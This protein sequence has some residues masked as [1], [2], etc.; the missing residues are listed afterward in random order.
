MTIGGI[1]TDVVGGADGEVGHRASEWGVAATKA[2]VVVVQCRVLAGAPNKSLVGN[3]ESAVVAYASA[4][5]G[6][7]GSN[8]VYVT[9]GNYGQT[10]VCVELLLFAVGGASAVGGIGTDIVDIV[11]LEVGHIAGEGAVAL[12][13][14]LMVTLY[15]W[16]IGGA[17]AYAAFGDVGAAVGSDIAAAGGAGGSNIGHIGSGNSRKI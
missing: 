1:G 5:G 9:N 4:T 12:P 17:P 3:G 8:I 15:G 13:H 16:K 7:G 14:S 10:T 11:G 2:D 6:A